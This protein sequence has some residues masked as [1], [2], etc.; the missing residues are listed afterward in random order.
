[1]Q[2]WFW[3][4]SCCRDFTFSKP[5]KIS[6]PGKVHWAYI[7]PISMQTLLL[8]NLLGILQSNVHILHITRALLR[9]QSMY[10]CLQFHNRLPDFKRLS[11]GKMSISDFGISKLVGALL[12]VKNPMLEWLDLRGNHIGRIGQNKF[13]WKFVL[14][15]EGIGYLSQLLF[16]RDCKLEHLNLSANRIGTCRWL[17]FRYS[18]Y[19]G[20]EDNCLG[21]SFLANVLSGAHPKAAEPDHNPGKIPPLKELNISKN[22]LC[23]EALVYLARCIRHNRLGIHI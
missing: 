10:L 23:G 11:L 3:R 8:D 9:Y 15:A 18:L 16:W 19:L 20:E 1:M 7:L 2:M 13:T 21:L 5:E 6:N 4:N 22:S 17:T 12:S 14:G